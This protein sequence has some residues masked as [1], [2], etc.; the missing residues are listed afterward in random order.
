MDYLDACVKLPID[1]SEWRK[2]WKWI[3]YPPYGAAHVDGAIPMRLEV[4]VSRAVSGEIKTRKLYVSDTKPGDELEDGI[5]LF[6]N[7]PL[8]SMTLY[9]DNADIPEMC[10]ILDTSDDD[11]PPVISLQF[12]LYR[13]HF[14]TD[15]MSKDELLTY[16][17]HGIDWN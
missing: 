1:F 15:I 8:P 17:E 4:F 3:D 16:L 2:T 14:D 6:E 5:D 11:G 13:P 10:L 7:Q 12:E 9:D